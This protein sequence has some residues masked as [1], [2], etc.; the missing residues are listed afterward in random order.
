MPKDLPPVAFY[1]QVKFEGNK[2]PDTSFQEVSGIKADIKTETVTGGGEH[3]DIRLPKSVD[4][5][6]LTLKR[7]LAPASSPLVKWCRDILTP[8]FAN[9]IIPANLV[10]TLL[11]QDGNACM[12]WSFTRAY[13]V[14]WDVDVFNSTEN[15]LAIESIVLTYHYFERTL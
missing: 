13:P 10:V 14:N 4:Y 3:Y 8:G 15:K 5:T 11:N 9:P 6:N 1:F 7:G 12:S 2:S